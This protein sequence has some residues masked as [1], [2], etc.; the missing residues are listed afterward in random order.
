MKV[1]ILVEWLEESLRGALAAQQAKETRSAPPPYPYESFVKALASAY[2][3]DCV[4]V[5][6]MSSRDAIGMSATC[7]HGH[8]FSAPIDERL[9]R[10]SQH[11][12]VPGLG[13]AMQCPKCPEIAEP[14]DSG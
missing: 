3:L 8:R 5:W 12:I 9:I 11:R 14:A 6:R 4:N 10:M 13:A 1:G 7:Q 2:G